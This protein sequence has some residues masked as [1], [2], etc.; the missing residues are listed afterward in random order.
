[1]VKSE[2]V[3]RVLKRGYPEN[4]EN[5]QKIVCDKDITVTFWTQNPQF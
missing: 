3:A 4:A 5:S 1:M 2:G